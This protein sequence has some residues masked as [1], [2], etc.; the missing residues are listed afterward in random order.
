MKNN[1]F[2]YNEIKPI[3]DVRQFLESIKSDAEIPLD[4]VNIFSQKLAFLKNS[5]IGPNFWLIIDMASFAF[6]GAGGN[7]ETIL[8]VSNEKLKAD[9]ALNSIIKYIYEEDRPYFMAYCQYVWGFLSKLSEAE[10]RNFKITILFRLV[11]KDHNPKWSIIHFFDWVFGTDKKLYYI[12]LSFTD[13]TQYKT[14]GDIQL[15]IFYNSDNNSTIYQT[16]SP[17]SHF[18]ISTEIPKISKRQKEI[19]ILLAKGHTSKEIAEKL[20]ISANTVNNH[21]QSLLNIT[22][23]PNV[24]AL[25]RY[26]YQNS[27]I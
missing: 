22:N 7:T 14:G 1:I 17:K 24:M 16:H 20:F 26:A 27:I 6:T 23:T 10:R 4:A 11:D 8:G 12:V 9:G 5:S 19:L 13:I 18:P 21:R 2:Q 25:V 3:D 15:N